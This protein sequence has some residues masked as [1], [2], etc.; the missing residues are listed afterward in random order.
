MR[1][2]KYEEHFCS[3]EVYI[4]KINREMSSLLKSFGFDVT[5]TM[6]SLISNG[7][8]GQNNMLSAVGALYGIGSGMKDT[9]K[10]VSGVRTNPG[11]FLWKLSKRK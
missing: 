10:L 3:N 6:A 4:N 2:K 1:K 5:I 7:W 9:L 11:F 8:T